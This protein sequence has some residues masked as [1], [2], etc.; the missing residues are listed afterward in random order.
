MP[1]MF[2]TRYGHSIEEVNQS[3]RAL[4][5]SDD[6]KEWE[7]L[8]ENFSERDTF[9]PTQSWPLKC[10]YVWWKADRARAYPHQPD[11]GRTAR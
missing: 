11:Y 4:L 7:R 9:C 1:T 5:H 3:I 10:Y 8:L 2:F 6:T